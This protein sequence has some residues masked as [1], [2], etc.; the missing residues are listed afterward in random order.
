MPCH[1]EDFVL[2][3]G[4]SNEFI[5]TVIAA[6]D[7]FLYTYHV[8]CKIDTCTNFKTIEISCKIHFYWPT[9]ILQLCFLL[10]VSFEIKITEHHH[11][12][13]RLNQS[14]PSKNLR[15]V[16][17]DH[18]HWDYKVSEDASELEQLGLRYEVLPPKQSFHVW[19]VR[20]HEIVAV[21]HCVNDTVQNT[22]KI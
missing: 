3:R 22:W 11:H 2:L 1:I 20:R 9:I 8:L 19:V 14:H 16:A 13:N 18:K 12:N 7:I 21:H 17:F 4:F 10:L 6:L 15:V 5:K